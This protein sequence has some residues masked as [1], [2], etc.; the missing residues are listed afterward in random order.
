MP[1]RSSPRVWSAPTVTRLPIIL[2]VVLLPACA[3]RQPVLPKVPETVTVVVEK[4]VTVPGELTAKCEA[5]APRE[6]SYSEAKRL[7]LLRLESIEQ[8]NRQLDK[9]RALSGEKTP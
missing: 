3:S 8:C 4:Y 6:Q 5:Y 1:G 7:A 9:I 2:A